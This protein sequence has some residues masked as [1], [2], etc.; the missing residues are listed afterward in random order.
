MSKPKNWT[1]PK[2]LILLLVALRC[3]YVFMNEYGLNPFKKSL[4]GDH[5]F[6]TGAGMGIGRMMALRLGKLGVKL[7]LADIQM[8]ALEETK[9]LLIEEGVPPENIN[10]FVCDVSKSESI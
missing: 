5:A 4:S 10:I 2:F 9:G 6:L 7:S 1:K 8:H 3:L